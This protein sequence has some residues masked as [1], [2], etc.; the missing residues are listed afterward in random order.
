MDNEKCER[1]LGTQCQHDL[2]TQIYELVEHAKAQGISERSINA[3]LPATA[4][5][6]R[7]PKGQ[8]RDAEVFDELFKCVVLANKKGLYDAADYVKYNILGL[9]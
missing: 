1:K 3:F 9:P 7:P 8:E 4:A 5:A 2:T 6:A